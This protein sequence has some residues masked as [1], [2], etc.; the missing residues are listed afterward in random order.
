MS[1]VGEFWQR[2]YTHWLSLK[3][4]IDEDEWSK[5]LPMNGENKAHMKHVKIP[6]KEKTNHPPKTS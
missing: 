5:N 1:W 6:P 2:N 4:N 3:G